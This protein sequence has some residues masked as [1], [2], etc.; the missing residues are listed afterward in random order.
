VACDI[1]TWRLLRLEI[2]HPTTDARRIVR[3]MI[4]ALVGS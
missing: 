1:L 2:G 3:R 4:S